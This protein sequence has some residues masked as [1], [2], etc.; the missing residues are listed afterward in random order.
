MA[1]EQKLGTKTGP[2][3]CCSVLGCGRNREARLGCQPVLPPKFHLKQVV[4]PPSYLAQVSPPPAKLRA[5]SAS[6]SWPALG[7]A[8]GEGTSGPGQ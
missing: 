8:S 6:V 3:P 4:A 7:E 2:D 1:W 5:G